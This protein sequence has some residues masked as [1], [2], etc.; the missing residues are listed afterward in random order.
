[1]GYM[2]FNLLGNYCKLHVY[3]RVTNTFAAVGRL[4]RFTASQKGEG[5][6][7]VGE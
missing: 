5:E 2:H 3:S 1:M 7:G 6:G 4:K